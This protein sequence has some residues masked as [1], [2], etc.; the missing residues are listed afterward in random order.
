MNGR[1]II[2]PVDGASN[3][4]L[5]V[6]DFESLACLHSESAPTP[7]RTVGNLAYNACTE[8]FAWFDEAIRALP[9]NLK[10]AAVIAPVARGASGGLI[11]SDNTLIEEPGE[12]LALAYTQRYPEKVEERFR[13]LAGS[14]EEF[15]VETGS[16]RDLPGSLTLLKRFVFEEMERPEALARSA[17]FAPQ[18]ILITGHF[19]GDFLHS[20]RVAGNEHSNWMCH[21]GTRD[22]RTASG[23]PSV[24]ARKIASFGRL[25]PPEPSTAYRPAGVLPSA[26]A[27]ALGL[28]GDTIV[29]PG[30]HDT[31]I[32]HIPVMSTFFHA[33]PHMRGKPVIQVEAGSWTMV[34]RIGGSADLPPDGFRRDILVQGTVDGEPVVTARYGGG[35]DFKEAR[36]I[37]EES[38][39]AFFAEPD[40]RLL[41]RIAEGAD[42]FVLPNLSPV[43][44]GTG[45]FP[46]L[47][48]KMVNERFLV[49]TPGAAPI[50]A[51]I[52]TSLAAAEQ[53]AAVSGD[54]EIP[55]AVTAGGAKDPYYARLLATFTGRGVY[56]P[57]DRIGSP[58][59]E[60][61]S[62]GA[63]IAGK[64]AR[65]GIHPYRVDTAGLG[66]EYRKVEQYGGEIARKLMG[67]ARRWKEMVKAAP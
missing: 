27:S 2:V 19:M 6:F 7:V 45:P 37:V 29:T 9:E 18:G 46:E 50:A 48:G 44:H 15:F 53:V 8:E 40:E 39:G 21:T 41:E 42:A 61:T 60:T 43:N 1:T 23:T 65:L 35:N 5:E 3:I 52:A 36:R 28:P 13:E 64:A 26:L 49:S 67:Y 16:I 47:R 22:I 55:L 25:V 59:T 33:F 31:C 38:G 66:I 24:A 10:R 30:G 51:S 56:A 4:K 17:G 54:P 32:S 12:G 14:A 62:L 34:A 20:W 63:A 58:V 11:G 57:F